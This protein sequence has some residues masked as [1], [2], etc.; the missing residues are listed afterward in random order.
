MSLNDILKT[1]KAEAEAEAKEIRKQGE[2]EV[3]KIEA[4]ID[5][6]SK[7]ERE[8]IL[9]RFKGELEKKVKQAKF[10]Q[11]SRTKT[12]IL[13]K[14]QKIL[15]TVYS[16][17]IDKIIGDDKI[18]AEVIKK[19]ADELPKVDE[20]EILL[21]SKNPERTKRALGALRLK[22]KIAD[23]TIDAKGGFVL[24]SKTFEIDNTIEALVEQARA[25]TEIEVCEI[26]FEK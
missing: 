26:L 15:D 3:K 6:L 10:V 18:Y 9:T 17:V 1:I 11:E 25:D 14:K 19:T 13:E 21:A 12:L 24:R 22:C 16:K 2:E 8:K 20:A 5:E 23:E 4:R 7:K